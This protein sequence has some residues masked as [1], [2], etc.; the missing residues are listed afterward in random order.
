M[1]P[2]WPDTA[3]DMTKPAYERD[4]GRLWV[5]KPK[6]VISSSLAALGWNTRVV[7][8]N[9]AVKKPVFRTSPVGYA[10]LPD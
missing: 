2:Y 10:V 1:I 8:A 4:Y 6:V 3:E 7:E 9:E 5:E